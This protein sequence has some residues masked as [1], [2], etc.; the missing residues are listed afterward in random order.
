MGW[1][2]EHAKSKLENS[3]DRMRT[4]EDTYKTKHWNSN[5]YN[6]YTYKHAKS[7]V[8]NFKDRKLVFYNFL[9]TN[10]TIAHKTGKL[11]RQNENLSI[12]NQINLYDKTKH[13]V[14]T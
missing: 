12:D 14:I 2:G 8:E 9:V 11:S 13:S 4:K 3:Q 10:T 6:I 5:F 7:K 1:G